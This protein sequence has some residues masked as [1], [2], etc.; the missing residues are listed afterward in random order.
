MLTLFSGKPQRGFCDTIPRRSF[1]QV[2][3][4]AFGGLSLPHLLRAEATDNLGSSNKSIIIVYLPGGPPHQDMFDLKLNAPREIRGEFQ[5]IATAT[6]GV[7]IC[8][9]LPRLAARMNRLAIIRSLVGAEHRHASFQCLTGRLHDDQPAGKWPE[10]GAVLSKLKGPRHAAIPPF[11]SLSPRMKHK[12]YNNGKAGFLGTAHAAF[13]P[14]GDG[15]HDLQLGTIQVDRLSN[16]GS[17][18][19]QLDMLRR[20]I[21]QSRVLDSADALQRQA[22]GIL[23]SSRLAEAL[24]LEKEDPK[25]RERY[26][27]GTEK[28]QGDAAPRL[29]QQFLMARRLIE[30]GARCVTLSYSF[31]DWHGQNFANARQNLPDLD[32]ALSALVDDLYDRGLDQNTTLLVWGEFGRTP[33]INKRSG[34]DHWPSVS[35]GLMSGGGLNTGQV[36]GSTDRL[37]AEAQDRPVHFQEVFATLY[38]ALGISPHRVTIPDL[39]GRP[40]YLVQG[41]Y[42][43]LP[44]LVG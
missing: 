10:I 6:P 19:E 30:A 36:I 3:G 5:P 18:L 12:P 7:Q 27:H 32:Q 9:L 40:R 35:C 16:R 15:H 13:Q 39:T 41:N 33:R 23:T 34:R 26:G 21:D 22:F 37:G 44:E 42:E 31:W 4:L 29:N 28:T 11:V 20:R 17:L 8:E 24:D 14:N 25:I 38:R 1:L 2:G 43:P